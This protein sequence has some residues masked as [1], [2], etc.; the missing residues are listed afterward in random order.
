MSGGAP[1]TSAGLSRRERIDRFRARAWALQVVY[2][3]ES[4]GGGGSLRDA[5]VDTMGTRRVAKRRIPRV[6]ALVVALDDHL[7]EVDRRLEEALDNWR[8]ER[9]SVIDRGILRLAAAELLY[10][11]EVPPR[12][13]I[14]EAIRLAESYGGNESPRFVNGVLDALYKRVEAELGL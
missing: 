13:S 6:R 10:V 2:R 14:Q 7:E 4:Q 3:W 1:G 8:L 12:V 5:L 11:E 9:L